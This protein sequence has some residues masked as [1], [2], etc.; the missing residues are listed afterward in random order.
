MTY[1]L[2]TKKNKPSSYKNSYI[3]NLVTTVPLKRKT[4]IKKHNKNIDKNKIMKYFPIKNNIYESYNTNGNNKL[5]KRK[6]NLRVGKK[7]GRKI[8]NHIKISNLK[9]KKGIKKSINEIYDILK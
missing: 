2:D 4:V 5:K 9:T 8:K 7:L 1:L 3:S 6:I